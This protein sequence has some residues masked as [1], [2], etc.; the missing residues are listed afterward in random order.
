[1]KLI[2]I[3]KIILNANFKNTE[4]VFEGIAQ[5]AF[6]NKDINDLN[7]VKKALHVREKEISTGL[8]NGFAIPHAISGS[9]L[10]PSLYIVVNKTDIK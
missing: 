7:V 5:L 2:N 3:N 1:M 8:E 6:K 9:V 4:K 10:K